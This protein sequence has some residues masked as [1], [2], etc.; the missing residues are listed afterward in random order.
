[1]AI[2]K[3]A[4]YK[5]SVET[6][7]NYEVKLQGIDIPLTGSLDAENKKR[8][9]FSIPPN[10]WTTVPE[11]VYRYL[12]AKFDAP[13]ETEVPDANANE[14]SPHQIGEEPIMRTEQQ[15]SWYLNFREKEQRSQAAPSTDGGWKK[16]E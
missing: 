16:G 9:V 15:Q 12:V 8:I 3:E 5:T 7:G 6:R 13:M 14:D 11:E 2:R 4:T 10:K 1:M